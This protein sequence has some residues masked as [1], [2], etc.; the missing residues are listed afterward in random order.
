[1]S[2]QLIVSSYNDVTVVEASDEESSNT[3]VEIASST[4]DETAPI[5]PD[6]N[7][8]LWRLMSRRYSRSTLF[9]FVIQY[10]NWGANSFIALPPP[11][12]DEA[13]EITAQR[14]YVSR[15]FYGEVIENRFGRESARRTYHL[16]QKTTPW[17]K[18]KTYELALFMSSDTWRGSEFQPSFVCFIF[19]IFIPYFAYLHGV[20]CRY[21]R[22]RPFLSRIS[23]ASRAVGM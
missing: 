2:K 12:P 20:I 1:M 9:T 11:E 21:R 18:V 4:A 8:T 14:K 10:L 15:K 5:D 3:D 13:K 17:K 23:S 16:L 22:R 19:P 6:K 7:I